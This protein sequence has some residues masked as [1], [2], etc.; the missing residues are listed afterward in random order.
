MQMLNRWQK[1]SLP[2][3]GQKTPIPV[4]MGG[5]KALLHT[6]RSFITASVSGVL[7]AVTKRGKKCGHPAFRVGKN[8]TVQDWAVFRISVQSSPFVPNQNLANIFKKFQIML[9][10]TVHYSVIFG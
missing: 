2:D 4:M 10:F 3:E 8:S 1:E 5:K 6:Y 9:R 7:K